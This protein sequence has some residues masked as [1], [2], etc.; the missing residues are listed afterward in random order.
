[1]TKK[2]S[3]EELLSEKEKYSCEFTKEQ[4]AIITVS[5]YEDIKE[6]RE[7]LEN[8]DML[9]KD[10]KELTKEEIEER[11]R[12]KRMIIAELTGTH[13]PVFEMAFGE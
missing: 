2:E 11:L 9:P 8:Y 7:I 5:I 6:E 12:Q 10:D 4:L 1:M 3:L 13:F